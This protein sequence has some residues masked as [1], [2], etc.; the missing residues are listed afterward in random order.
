M[1]ANWDGDEPWCDQCKTCHPRV[2]AGCSKREVDQVTGVLGALV[3]SLE[4]TKYRIECS[5]CSTC[6]PLANAIKALAAR[7]EPVPMTSVG[8]VLEM[9]DALADVVEATYF[10]TLTHT[11]GPVLA[12]IMAY[13]EKRKGF[14]N[15]KR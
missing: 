1:P 14:P 13:R 11:G 6:T 8:P 12:A 3:K 2:C 5:G 9:C 7:G 4:G 15:A 10:A